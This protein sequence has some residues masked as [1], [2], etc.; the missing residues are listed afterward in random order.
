LLFIETA[1]PPVSPAKRNA[2]LRYAI[3]DKLTI[4]PSTVH[5]VVVGKCAAAAGKSDHARHVVAAIDRTWLVGVLHWLK[6]AGLA[7]D[8]LVAGAAGVPVAP[9]QW[10]VVLESQRGFAKRADGFLYNLDVG[11]GTEPPFGLTLALK[12]AREHQRTPSALVL[13][14]TLSRKNAV[15]ADPALAG[16]WQQALG[17]PVTIAAPS[18]D[19]LPLLLAESKSANLLTG[20]FAPRASSEKWIRL[21]TPASIVLTLMVT[22][23]IIFTLFDTWRLDRER[24]AIEQD[25]TQVFKSAF[26]T[27]QAIVDPALQMRRNLQQLKSERG[28]PADTDARLLIARLTGLTQALPGGRLEV[29]A[30][31]VADGMA[32][33]DVTLA[34]PD[35]RAHLQRAV[36]RLPDAALG[37]GPGSPSPPASPLSVRLTLRAGT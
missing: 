20:E 31:A 10:A 33:L 13:R 19:N 6:Q 30:L 9:G 29:T 17:V 22:A 16:R 11:A 3:E 26:P 27:A 36:D 28:L 35:Q 5:A 21:L 7:P 24:E 2:L 23:H 15:P 1:L 12:E 14:S 4:D 32:T 37:D 34:S 25:M 8:S 18:A